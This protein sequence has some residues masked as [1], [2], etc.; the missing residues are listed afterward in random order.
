MSELLY[1]D[2]GGLQ[3]YDEL[4]KSKLAE[5]AD[6]SSL[7]TAATKDVPSSGN[8]SSSQ[9]V[10]G[11]DTRLT[12]SRNAKDVYDWA[13]AASKPSYTASEVGLGNVGN[14]KAVSTVA[15]QG[16]SSTEQSNARANIGAGTSSFSGNYN[17]LTNKPTIPT[18]NNATLT[19]QRNGTT[20]KA[21]TAN[22]SSNVTAD[23]TVPTKVSDLSNDSG[24]TTNTGT[25]TK[26]TAGSGLSIGTTAGGNFTTTGTINHTN[27][28]TA[29][30]TQAI[31]PI[32][33]DAQGHISAYGSAISP[34]TG[35]TTAAGT[36]INSVGTPSVSA[37]TSNGTTTL[38]FNYLKGASGSNGTSAAWFTG[39]AVTGTGTSGISASVSGSK[40]N[41]MYLNTS[42]YNV[43]KATAANT[44]GYV[45]NIKGTNGTTPTIQAASGTNIGTAGTPTV[46]ASTSGTTTTFTFNY[47]KGATGST[48]TR[49]SV[50]N[51]GT[52]VTG[53]S[54]TPAVF[55]TGLSSSLVNDLYL[56]TSTFNVYQCTT[57]GNASTA[58]WKYIGNIKGTNG[59]NATTT[60]VFND[61]NNGLAP[62]TASGNQTT[63]E[64]S[65]SVKYLCS[66]GKWRPLPSGAWKTG[67]VTSTNHTITV[68]SGYKSDGTTAISATSSSAS[69]PSV[70]LG[71]SGVTAGSYG[72][73]AA[74]TPAYGGTFK[75]PYVTVNAKGIVT[76]ISE[77]TV[78]VPS[79]DNSNNA[80]TQTAT[81]TSA[82]YE[83]L[84]SATADNTTRTE[85]ARKTST[86]T[87]NPSTKELS[88]GGAVNG[89]TLSS[90]TTGFK[91]SG[92]TTSKTLTVE[93]DY[94]LGAACAKGV[95][96]NSSNADV[97][98]SDTNLI[99]GR[100][101]YYQ[102]A[103]KGYT[104]NTGTV[105]SVGVS[106]PTGLSVS[107][108]PVTSSGTIAISLD[109]DYTIPTSTAMT[110][111]SNA[112]S[113][114]VTFGKGVNTANTVASLA[115]N[116]K[117]VIVTPNSAAQSLSIASLPSAGR[118]LHI[119][120]DNS[121]GSSDVVITIPHGPDNSVTYVNVNDMANG[122][123][124]VAAGKIG[125]INILSASSKAWIR[126]ISA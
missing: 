69:S 59:T 41:D 68:G 5:K 96:D 85:G 125:E 116:K 92:G 28:V 56:N 74:Q 46:T 120:V 98:S 57:A 77:H 63:A 48:G 107:N 23:I 122:E 109:S 9:V 44:W 37:S 97:T 124:T 104:T 20:V 51:W 45:C 35:V 65:S 54:T 101:L 17:D 81:T 49:G 126:Y 61:S 64:T 115:V 58:K 94:T 7:G 15:N 121:A 53:T 108:S 73:S 50:F 8:A 4:I 111:A 72:D 55:A 52:D 90:Q 112:Y 33:I 62:S 119:M 47:L 42:T 27:S 40:A 82:A 38:T 103:K 21:F 29:Q 19:I 66:D 34:I 88:T 31:Y 11:N 80:V 118:D 75:V 24:Y 84:F 16:L 10:M 3:R 106:V 1:L 6:S 93:A 43:Y 30:T 26:V 67:T 79:S 60:S 123:M 2:Y 87:Y 83:V 114:A 71:D 76:G 95:T 13:K 32:K 113:E 117:L 14:F 78:T 25:V 39:T 89:L 91:V 12:D 70:T 99:T 36:N 18:V 100:T 102:L 22:A 110:H 105:T 86:L